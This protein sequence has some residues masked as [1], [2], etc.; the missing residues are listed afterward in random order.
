MFIPHLP[1]SH[2]QVSFTQI[3]LNTYPL[4]TNFHTFRVKLSRHTLSDSPSGIWTYI[5]TFSY[6]PNS[7][8]THTDLCQTQPTYISD[9]PTG[10]WTYIPTLANQH[11]SQVTKLSR[12]TY[13]TT[14]INW[15]EPNSADTPTKLS[16]P[17]N[18]ELNDCN[19]STFLS[20]YRT[21]PTH[22]Q[23]YTHHPAW[24]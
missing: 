23:N 13:Q 17:T 1:I 14:H 22:I 5:P 6:L 9:I 10:L 3:I 11:A 12:H 7:I 21:Q 16:T 24:T 8:D 19:Q 20:R 2:S 18:V 4:R 15:C